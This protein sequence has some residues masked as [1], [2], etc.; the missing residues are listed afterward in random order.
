MNSFLIFQSEAFLQTLIFSGSSVGETEREN[1]SINSKENTGFSQNFINSSF[2]EYLKGDN[3]KIEETI[4]EM[5]L[6]G[7]E[8]TF[9][10]NVL[11]IEG[12]D[13]DIA[14]AVEKMKTLSCKW[15]KF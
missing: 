10:L 6:K 3:R 1:L 13:I 11:T 9:P 14:A 15:K 12:N 7:E 2:Y 8:M 4:K 5:D